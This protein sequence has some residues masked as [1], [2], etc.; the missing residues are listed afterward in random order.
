MPAAVASPETRRGI[1]A[2]V[3]FAAALFLAL[4][5]GRAPAHVPYLAVAAVILFFATLLH[6]E[7]GLVILILSMLLSPEL[8][9]GNAGGTGLQGSRDVVLRTEDLILLLVGLAW[10]A[11]M[12]IHK[13]L[14]AIRRTRLNAFIG[15]YIA[16]CLLSTLIGIETG[17]VR[18][19]VGLCYVAKYVEYFILFFITVNYVRS[20]RQLRRLLAA[21]LITAAQIVL[22]A[23]WQIPSGVRPSAPFEG[24]RGE[25]N[26]LGGYLVMMIAVSA[27]I[28][29]TVDDTRWRRGCALLAIGSVPPLLATLSRSSWLALGG[30][31]LTLLIL[32]PSRR[33]LALIAALMLVILLIVHPANVVERIAYTFQGGEGGVGIGSMHLDSSSSARLSSW[34]SGLEAFTRHPF[35]GWGITG[36]GF[37]DAQYFRVLVELGLIGL[38]AFAALLAATG[39]TFHLAFRRLSDPLHRGLALG[40]AAAFGG[41]LFHAIG[42]NTFILIRIMEP[43]WLLTGLVLAAMSMEASPHLDEADAA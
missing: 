34:T 18:A 19:V 17:R 27:A 4:W 43:F 21:V 26:T 9:L 24:A 30:M 40:M 41:L 25:P 15:A 1:Q 7:A 22:Y 35:L 14:G 10:I 32:S 3:A 8:A 31:L 11:R 16:S 33:R 6:A 2:L 39:R 20:P 5:V 13:D 29:L 28:A 38:I 23:Y 37:L 36:Y 12:A 42:A